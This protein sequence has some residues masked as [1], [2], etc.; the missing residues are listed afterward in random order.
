MSPTDL[1]PN[2][3]QA[4]E[5]TV[6]TLMELQRLDDRLGGLL[7][8]RGVGPAR[9]ARKEAE[10]EKAA[11]L[12]DE[13]HHQAQEAQ[14][15]CDNKE[16]DVKSC[17]EHIHKL[18]GQRLTVRKNEEYRA[19]TETIEHELERCSQLEEE[20]LVFLTRIDEYKA[21]Q[22]QLTREKNRLESELE[23]LRA[24]VQA[25]TRRIDGESA[26]VSKERDNTARTV[27]LAVLEKYQKIREGRGGRAVVAVVD[28]VCQGCSMGVTD[29]TVN[30][31]ILRRELVFCENC[32]RILYLSED[33]ISELIKGPQEG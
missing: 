2:V 11:R 6:R 18:E 5:E 29:Q 26:A 30:R 9:L 32:S 15:E 13:K 22:G 19:L 27:P 7:E 20:A 21:E 12:V 23:A 24:E 31:L 16:L 3:Q 25:E 4:L 17:E 10:L 14:K 33:S 8:Q 1:S 28:S